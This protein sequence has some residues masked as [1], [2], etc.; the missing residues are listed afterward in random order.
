MGEPSGACQERQSWRS[1]ALGPSDHAGRCRSNLWLRP[2]DRQHEF[3]T[4]VSCGVHMGD[5][6]TLN[7]ERRGRPALLER[8]AFV[9]R[10]HGGPEVLTVRPWAVPFPGDLQVRVW[11]EAAGISYSDLLMLHGLHPE[12]RRAPFVPG[13]DVVVRSTRSGPG[14][15]GCASVIVWLL[16]PSW[17]AGRSASSCTARSWS[18]CRGRLPR[19]MRFVS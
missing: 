16:F 19:Q 9:A 1:E 13:W 14:W 7:P 4:T 10:R 2:C 6:W 11:V 15:K 17:V 5:G 8:D 18:G 12:R 3:Q